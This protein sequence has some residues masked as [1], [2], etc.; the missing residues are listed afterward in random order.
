MAARPQAGDA[1][2]DLLAFI[3]DQMDPSGKMQVEQMLDGLEVVVLRIGRKAHQGAG[4]IF[5]FL[6]VH[7]IAGIG[8]ELVACVVVPVQVRQDDMAHVLGTDIDTVEQLKGAFLDLIGDLHLVKASLGE[9]LVD[10]DGAFLLVKDAP[11][12]E[13]G[14][15]GFL[16]VGTHVKM[17]GDDDRLL[18]GGEGIDGTG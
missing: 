5:Q 3:L 16:D 12:E 4:H 11:E 17:V 6:L 14:A 8:I 15:Q 13:L 1:F 7:M 9:R 18:A 10:Q 2:A